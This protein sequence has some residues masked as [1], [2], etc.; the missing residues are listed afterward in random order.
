MKKVEDRFQAANIT[1]SK[2]RHHHSEKK[3]FTSLYLDDLCF[4]A[5]KAAPFIFLF[6]F[7][8]NKICISTFYNF[9]NDFVEI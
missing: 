3:I 7:K 2:P 8:K 9:K 5:G 6:S 1:V 4:P